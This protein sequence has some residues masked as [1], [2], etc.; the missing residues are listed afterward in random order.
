MHLPY[1]LKKLGHLKNTLMALN[2]KFW[3]YYAVMCPKNADGI[4]DNIGP[5]V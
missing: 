2:G 3:F 5:D 4:A 1:K